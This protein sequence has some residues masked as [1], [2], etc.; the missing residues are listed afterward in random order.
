MARSLSVAMRLRW[1]GQS[2]FLLTA[3]EGRVMIDPFGDPSALSGRGIRFDYPPIAGVTADLVLVTHEHFDHNAAEVVDGNPAV[4]RLAGT[5]ETPVGEVVGVAS[6]HDGEAGTRRGPNA[7]FR[8]TLDGLRVCHLGDFGQPGLRAEQRA[9]LGDVDVL[10]APVGGGPTIGP[11]QAAAIAREL[12]A[13]WIVPMH[14]A[15]PAADFLG[16]VDP[17]LEAFD[18]VRRLDG[19]EADIEASERPGSPCV[20]VPAPP[21]GITTP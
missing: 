20:L 11:E 17:F 6:E 18:D 7:I 16:P 19:P 1:Y 13:A 9:A 8:L 3:A 21:A 14:Y 2:A 12:N 5:H 10:L 4:V 15:T